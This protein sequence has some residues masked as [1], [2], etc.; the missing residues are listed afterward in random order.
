VTAVDDQVFAFFNTPLGAAVGFAIGTLVAY[1]VLMPL[2]WWLDCRDRRRWQREEALRQQ[3]VA[4][5]QQLR[6]LEDQI[7][8][9]SLPDWMREAIEAGRRQRAE[10]RREARRRMGLPEEEP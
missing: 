9:E 4:L 8:H 1:L 5:R 2:T 10:I 6:D 3:Q 7:R